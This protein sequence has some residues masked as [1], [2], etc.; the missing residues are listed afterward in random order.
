MKNLFVYSTRWFLKLLIF[1]NKYTLNEAFL[2][3][4]HIVDRHEI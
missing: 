2:L 1:V 3:I 4:K